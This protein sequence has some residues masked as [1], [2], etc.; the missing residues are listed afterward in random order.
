[1]MPLGHLG[2]PLLIPLVNKDLDLDIRLLM[3]GAFLPDIIDKPLG[4]L[5]LPE[6]NGRIF[7][8]TLAFSVLILIIGLKFRPFLSLS[9]GVTFHHILD[10]IFLDV[11]TALWPL[12]G[13]FIRSDFEVYDWFE[14]FKDPFVIG[15]ELI[16]LILMIYF[17]WSFGLFKKDRSLAFIKHGKINSLQNAIYKKD[18]E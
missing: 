11:E 2:I 8:H 9:I 15:E 4:H 16:G 17:F 18:M 10:G 14:A 5:L 12:L 13:P 3:L 6:N 7:A 1:M